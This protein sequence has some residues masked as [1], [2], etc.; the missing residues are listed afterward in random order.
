MLTAT[1][2]NLDIEVLSRLLMRRLRMRLTS[3]VLIL[4][5]VEAERPALAFVQLAVY[6]SQRV[7][8]PLRI[9]CY[10]DQRLMT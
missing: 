4:E 3:S 6:V 10:L 7:V 9:L 1:S 2:V 5:K 8:G